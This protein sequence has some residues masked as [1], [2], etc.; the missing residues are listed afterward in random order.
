MCLIML[1]RV[2]VSLPFYVSSID[3]E[4]KTGNF[5]MKGIVSKSDTVYTKNHALEKTISGR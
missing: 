2:F 5:L 3:T 1:I 4:R